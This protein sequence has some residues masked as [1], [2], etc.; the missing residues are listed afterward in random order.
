MN[1]KTTVFSLLILAQVAC[2]HG[3]VQ[4]SRPVTASDSVIPRPLEL[5]PIQPEFVYKI[6]ADLDDLRQSFV[7]GRDNC[8]K[9]AWLFP[10]AAQALKLQ[11]AA[12]DDAATRLKEQEER[13]ITALSALA[14]VKPTRQ[15]EVYQPTK[16]PSVIRPMLR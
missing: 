16:Q 9:N 1:L 4:T 10:E 5:A 14:L 3:Q 15:P 6:V 13:I 8:I 12:Y 7:L 2:V 11:A